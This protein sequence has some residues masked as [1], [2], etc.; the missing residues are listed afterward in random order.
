MAAR[1]HE[2]IHHRRQDFI[3]QQVAVL[4]KRFGFIAVETLLVRNMVK[5]PK[6]AKSIADVAWSLFFTHLTVK[7]EEAARCVVK[8]PAAYTTQTCAMCGHR[9]PMPL[10]VR[11]YECH[12]C[13]SVLHRD[14]NASLTILGLGR[15][16]R[17]V[18]E[19]SNL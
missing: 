10:S 9:Q 5:N 14:H 11:I 12:A 1:I 17:N 7:A 6:P 18:P 15:Q 2:R 4:I 16:A 13:H 8:V 3:Y 19:A